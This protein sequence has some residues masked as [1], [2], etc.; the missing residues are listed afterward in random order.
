[1]WFK[2][3]TGQKMPYSIQKINESKIGLADKHKILISNPSTTKKR[4]LKK[5]ARNRISLSRL[6]KLI[7]YYISIIILINQLIIF[8]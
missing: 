6:T 7:Y 4:N 3:S 2:A 5:S 1:L 8:Q